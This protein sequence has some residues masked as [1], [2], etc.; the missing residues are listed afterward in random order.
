MPAAELLLTM[1]LDEVPAVEPVPAG[2]RMPLLPNPLFVG[3]QADLIVLAQTLQGAATAAIGQVAAA[4]GLG[5]IGKTQL[6]GEFAYRY[7]QY[8]T[9][10]ERFASKCRGGDCQGR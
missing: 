1:P 10:R 3:R 4:T 6:A 2:S 5:G 9:T 8:F 7:G